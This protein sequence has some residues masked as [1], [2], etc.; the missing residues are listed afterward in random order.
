M[1][2]DTNERGAA[3]L[4]PESLETNVTSVCNPLAIP[5]AD[6]PTQPVVLGAPAQAHL[7]P[8]EPDGAARP[9]LG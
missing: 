6:V 9:R 2:F 8:P 1:A 5:S 7:L 3:N 4:A